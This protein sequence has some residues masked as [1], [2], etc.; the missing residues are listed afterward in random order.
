MAGYQTNEQLLEQQLQK[1]QYKIADLETILYN[2]R[3]ILKNEIERRKERE[4]DLKRDRQLLYS[5]LDGLP[6]YVYLIAADYSFYFVNR[7]F[8]D[9]FGDPRGK[10]CYQVMGNKESACA[11]CETMEVFKTNQPLNWEWQHSEEQVYEINAYPFSDG[12][13]TPLVLTLA[14]DITERK[15]QEER[16]RLS[17]EQLTKI[18]N[19]APVLI[20][21]QRLSDDVIESVNECFVETTGYTSEEV[22]G[23][24]PTELNMIDR[25]QSELIKQLINE[26]GSIRNLTVHIRT[27]S[28]EIREGLLS[29]EVLNF[30]GE[31]QLLSINNDITELKRMEQEMA[32]LD[33][34]NL[35]AGMAAGIGHEIRNPMTTVRGLLQI[36]KNRDTKCNQ[37]Q[38]NFDVMISELDRANEIISEYLSLARKKPSDLKLQNLNNIIKA[39]FPLIEANA[40]VTG[41]CATLNLGEVP[42]LLL[43]GSEMR[44]LIINLAKNGLEA[45]EPG[46]KLTIS[47]YREDDEVTLAVQ[48]EGSGIK[49]E[50]LEKLGTPFFTTKDNGTGLGLATCYSIAARHNATHSIKTDCN[51]TIFYIHFKI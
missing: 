25:D 36:L 48:D 9:I 20:S 51:G 40:I 26:K 41:K 12:S 49:P 19:A 17:E 46:Q 23:K 5:I 8:Y 34:L 24:T 7:K 22:M 18:I 39:L 16:L 6:A 33:R 3:K 21:R 14:V 10:K 45:M 38:Q 13:G 32:K 15:R 31:L 2:E 44:Q 47:T 43:D 27:K 50:Y 4:L 42:D 28:G 1:L 30:N 11:V 37:E 35:V 29:S